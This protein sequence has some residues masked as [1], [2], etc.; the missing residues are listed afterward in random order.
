M[1]FAPTTVELRQRTDAPAPTTADPE[2]TP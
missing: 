2:E 1:I